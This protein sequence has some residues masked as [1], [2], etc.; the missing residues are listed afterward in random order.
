M[1]Q[2]GI[3][4][5][6]DVHLFI[7]HLQTN[8]PQKGDPHFSTRTIITGSLDEVGVPRSIARVDVNI[9]NICTK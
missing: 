8:S 9:F 3:I 4:K 5:K 7:K 6:I 2:V 1:Y